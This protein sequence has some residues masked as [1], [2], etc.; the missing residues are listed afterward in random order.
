MKVLYAPYF[1]LRR[2]GMVDLR[3]AALFFVLLLA[4]SSTSAAEE[5]ADNSDAPAPA[6]TTRAPHGA[7]VVLAARVALR[8]RVT[9]KVGDRDGAAEAI[10]KKAGAMGGY[11]TV[12]D[13]DHVVLKV[14][15]TSLKSL[16]E[17]A[18]SLGAVV[19]LEVEAVDVG[20]QLQEQTTLLHSREEVLKRYFAVMRSAGVDTIVEVEAAMTDLVEEIEELKGELKVLKH[21]ANFGELNVAFQFHD[22]RPPESGGHSSFEWINSVNLVDL[23]E[24][25]GH[26]E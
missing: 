3:Y 17:Y 9:V 15:R 11:F 5:D 1:I 16:Q 10:I 21:R 12:R 18:E 26:A 2:I 8:S 7:E 13:N 20:G 24:D 6:N 25:F 4:T 22:R 14:P 19:G 23:M